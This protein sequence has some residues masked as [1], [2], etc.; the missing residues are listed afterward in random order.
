MLK[1]S[2][3]F[4][5]YVLVIFNFSYV[6]QHTESHCLCTMETKMAEIHGYNGKI[7]KNLIVGSDRL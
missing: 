7:N 4:G 2:S 6:A 5:L 3:V 1:K